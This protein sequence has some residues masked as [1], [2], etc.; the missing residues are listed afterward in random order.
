MTVS[1]IPDGC[2]SITPYLCIKGA[3]EAIE[4]YKRAFDADEVFRLVTPGGEIGHAEIRIGNSSFMLSE[5]CSQSPL[6]S[7]QS[8]GG[9]SVGL[10]LYV[11]DVDAQFAKAVDAGAKV[12]SPLLDQF[13]GDRTGVLKDPFGHVWYL[14]SH[15]E[16]LSHEEISRR[17]EALFSA[18]CG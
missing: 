9:S 14:A 4:F 12:I 8:Q 11:E 5:A 15:T 7:P 2:H 6:L 1:P 17:A 3:T 13:Y 16:D 18:Q 10:Y